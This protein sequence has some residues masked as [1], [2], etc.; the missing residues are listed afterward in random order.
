MEIRISLCPELAEFVRRKVEG[1]EYPAADAL[2]EDALL[3][4]Q[5]HESPDAESRRIDELRKAIAVGIDQ[6][7][8]GLTAPLDLD[9]IRAEVAARLQER[10]SQGS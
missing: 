3:L 2:I 10:S 5:G 1:G 9:D 6:A 8:Q 7:D 4:L